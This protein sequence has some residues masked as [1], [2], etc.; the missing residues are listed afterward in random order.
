VRWDELPGLESGAHW[1]VRTVH[2]RLDEG[3]APW[4]EYKRSSVLPTAAMK[5]LG[6][7]P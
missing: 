1:T 5:T 7:Q 3:N 4:A 2:E 6:F